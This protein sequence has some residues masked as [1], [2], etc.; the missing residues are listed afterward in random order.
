MSIA[1][2]Y[3]FVYLRMVLLI[4]GILS[5]PLLACGGN[6][7]APGPD[8]SP[9]PT[10]SPSPAST[11]FPYGKAHATAFDNVEF[12]RGLEAATGRQSLLVKITAFGILPTG[13][14]VASGGSWNY[15]F[16]DVKDRKLYLWTVYGDDGAV[17]PTPDR[18]DIERLDRSE[19]IPGTNIDSPRAWKLA[20]RYGA[21]P[22]LDRYP[23]A[24]SKMDCRFRAGF[25]TWEVFFFDNSATPRP[26][27]VGPIY[28]DARNGELLSA[29]LYCLT[30][31]P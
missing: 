3:G 9:S 22:Y 11:P 20:L 14:P 2:E 26:C 24:H 15:I 29:N 4:I 30:H 31:L 10:P 18:P 5:L 7:A 27:G 17:V 1:S 28:I 25:P 19:L 8:A 6:P 16:S 23:N 13:A 12:V 21:Q